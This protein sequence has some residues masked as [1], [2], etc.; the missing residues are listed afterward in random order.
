MD[1]LNPVQPGV[2]NMEPWRLKRDFG[3]RLSFHGGIDVVNVLP[4]LTPSEVRR[5]V[6]E[7]ISSFAP[8]GGYILAASHNVQDDTPPANV[9]AMYD[10]AL[11]L[12]RYPHPQNR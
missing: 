9:V 2:R 3:D 6:G 5:R 12:G 8:G 1:I 4:K 11:D 7:G 10:A